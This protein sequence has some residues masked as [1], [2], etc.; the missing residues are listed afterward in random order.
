M[1]YRRERFNLC[2]VYLDE[3]LLHY[4]LELRNKRLVF[5]TAYHSVLTP[6]IHAYW[7]CCKSGALPDTAEELIA[8]L[9]LNY[10]AKLEL[11]LL[12]LRDNHGEM[13]QEIP[14]IKFID[15][16]IDNLILLIQNRLDQ[17]EPG[18]PPGCEVQVQ[19]AGLQQTPIP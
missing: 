15:I 7:T 14:R 13:R 18:L 12:I 17:V 8:S 10:S 19:T 11:R 3:A 5:F 4:D 16:M 6:L 1:I 9:P 2:R